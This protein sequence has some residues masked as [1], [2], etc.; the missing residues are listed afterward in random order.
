MNKIQVLD[1]IENIVDSQQQYDILLSRSQANDYE[2]EMVVKVIGAGREQSLYATV[3][4]GH[5]HRPPA[6]NKKAAQQAEKVF[7]RAS[8]KT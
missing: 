5:K 2:K 7:K 1:E 4:Q 3:A 6:E 8:T